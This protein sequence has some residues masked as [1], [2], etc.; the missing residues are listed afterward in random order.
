MD[1]IWQLFSSQKD[2]LTHQSS[3]SHKKNITIPPLNTEVTWITCPLVWNLERE[4]S[5]SRS[6]SVG[7]MSV[8]AYAHLLLAAHWYLC[9]EEA[10]KQKGFRFLRCYTWSW[11]ICCIFLTICSKY[12]QLMNKDLPLALHSLPLNYFAR[13]WS[14][15]AKQELLL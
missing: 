14:T 13:T 6:I 2:N 15:N 4:M 11:A 5:L 3:L 9:P 12:K 8:Q 10:V 7:H 1:I